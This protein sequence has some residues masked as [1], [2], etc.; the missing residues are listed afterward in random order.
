LL[1]NDFLDFLDPRDWRVV[2]DEAARAEE[3]A[4]A[5]LPQSPVSSGMAAPSWIKASLLKT[6]HLRPSLASGS[7][8]LVTDS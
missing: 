5:A 6:L 7:N 3:E 8:N 2:D 1:F 4:A